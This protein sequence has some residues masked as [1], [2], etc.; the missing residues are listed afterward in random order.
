[1]LIDVS[2]DAIEMRIT[3]LAESLSGIDRFQEAQWVEAGAMIMKISVWWTCAAAES[4]TQWEDNV[5]L[6]TGTSPTIGGG[7]IWSCRKVTCAGRLI[8][9]Q[10]QSACGAPAGRKTLGLFKSYTL[11]R[12]PREAQK[13][14][15]AALI[16]GPRWRCSPARLIRKS[17]CELSKH[18]EHSSLLCCYWWMITASWLFAVYHSGTQNKHARWR[19]VSVSDRY[20]KIHFA[21]QFWVTH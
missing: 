15:A 10:S 19:L 17:M 2:R 21:F 4:Q 11:C 16:E 3:G 7:A 18:N 12:L 6:I 20:M 5:K 14:K 13:R 8:S 1:M 9:K